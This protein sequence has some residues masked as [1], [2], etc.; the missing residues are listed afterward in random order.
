MESFSTPSLL[1]VNAGKTQRST[2]FFR[3]TELL[4]DSSENRLA[5]CFPTRQ[6][7]FTVFGS[8]VIP[9][10]LFVGEEPDKAKN[11]NIR[12]KVHNKTNNKE[13]MLYWNDKYIWCQ[14][15]N[16][17]NLLTFQKINAIINN[18]SLN[19][20]FAF[21]RLKRFWEGMQVFWKNMFLPASDRFKAFRQWWSGS[22]LSVSKALMNNGDSCFLLW[23]D[24]GFERLCFDEKEWR[25]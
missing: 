13:K 1:P 10:F 23:H 19:A 25:K 5:A 21:Q 16:I 20:F 7:V 3:V 15:L 17:W 14:D 8:L 24:F 2:L 18:V 4:K 12:K 11:G 9:L 6:L 22:S